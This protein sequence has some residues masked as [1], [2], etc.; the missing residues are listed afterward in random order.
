MKL[1]SKILGIVLLIIILLLSIQTA[2]A[3]DKTPNT[4]PDA[5]SKSWSRVSSVHY[6]MR[7]NVPVVSYQQIAN[8]IWDN[9]T[10][11]VKVKGYD[12][13]LQDLNL[14]DAFTIKKYEPGLWVRDVWGS[15]WQPGTLIEIK[16]NGIMQLCYLT[17]MGVVGNQPEVNTEITEKYVDPD[18]TCAPSEPY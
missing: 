3:Q 12:V 17:R 13:Y 8:F 14:N 4:D 1:Y 10:G 11:K 18:G 5:V 16:K 7:N 2:V 15:N 9:T 6:I